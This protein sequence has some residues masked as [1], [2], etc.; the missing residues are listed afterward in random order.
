MSIEHAAQTSATFSDARVLG[1]EHS[2]DGRHG[3]VLLAANDGRDPVAVLCERAGEDWAA[4]ATLER[5]GWIRTGVD[6]EAPGA[7]VLWGRAEPGVSR[8]V[9][10]YGEGEHPVP[11]RDGFFLFAAW[12]VA[13]GDG[14]DHPPRL[15]GFPS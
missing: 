15:I 1:V 12:D 10:G 13:P 14:E 6:E 2:P 8:A 9:V 4:G 3:V 5:P 11:V 7:Y